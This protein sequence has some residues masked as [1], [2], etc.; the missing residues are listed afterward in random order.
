MFSTKDNIAK[1]IQALNKEFK[2]N[3]LGALESEESFS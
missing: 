1:L 3:Y 2:V